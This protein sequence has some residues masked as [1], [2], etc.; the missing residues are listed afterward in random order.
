MATI[1]QRNGSYQIVV[2]CGYDSKGKHLRRS[3]TWRPEPGM[4]ARQIEKALNQEAALFEKRVKDGDSGVA[5]KAIKFEQLA[6]EW[7]SKRA[8]KKLKERTVSRLH[9]LTERTYSALGAKRVDKITKRDIQSFIDNLS[10]PGV[11]QQRIK[12]DTPDEEVPPAGLSP[13]T[14]RHYLSFV[15]NV[16]NYAVDLEM[17]TANPAVNIELPAMQ[18]KESSC[19]TME[20][21]AQFLDLLL[22]EEWQYKMFFVLAIYSGARRAELLGL[23]WKDMDFSN[24]TIRICRNSLYTKRKGIYTDTVKTKGSNRVLKLPDFVFEMLHEYRVW[25]TEQRFALGDQW[26]D[27]DR[28]FTQWNGQPMHP[29]SPATWL[30]KFCKRTGM[31][32]TNVHSFRHL[33]ASMLINANI[34]PRTVSATL[35][36]SNTSTTLGIY[37]HVFA[38]AKAKAAEA[39]GNALPIKPKA[40]N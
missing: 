26:Q 27:C 15:S 2:S 35:G 6:D 7:L 10:E 30:S 14:V 4:T 20:E 36:H 33:N 18:T 40:A 29:N 21:A 5:V 34:D 17:I 25:Q 31:R 24:H 9:S 38:E 23:E 1:K 37:S 28:L 3:M 32:Y 8:E 12:K 19:Y 22:K 39:V 13:K 16:L 11:K